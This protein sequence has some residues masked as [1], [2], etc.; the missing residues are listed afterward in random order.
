MHLGKLHGYDGGLIVL[1]DYDVGASAMADLDG[2]VEELP[3]DRLHG[4]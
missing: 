4:M 3:S 2:D 1:P